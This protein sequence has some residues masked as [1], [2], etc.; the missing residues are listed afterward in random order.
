MTTPHNPDDFCYRHPD[1]RSYVLCQ[2]C[3]RTVCPECQTQAA[4][5]VICPEC[6]KAQRQATP[7]RVRRAQKAVRA[8]DSRPVVTYWMML[9]TA[10]V[11]ITAYIPGSPV[12]GWLMFNSAFIDSGSGAPFEP[13][14]MLTSVFTHLAFWHVGLNILA[15]WMIGRSLAPMLGHGRFLALYLL[16]GFGGSV[17]VALIAPGVSV[18]GASGAVFGLLGALLVVGRHLGANVTGILIILGI[19]LVI[20]F[21]PGFTVAWQAHVGGLATGALIGW[22]FARTRRSDQRPLQIGLLVATG[23]LLLALTV[24]ATFI[25]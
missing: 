7:P 11:F 21:I 16:S 15:I 3:T 1:R 25:Y 2:R 18:V 4:V 23:V 19:N 14:R 13:W 12:G 6:M 20:G 24:L 8:L 10:V 17:G 22:I 9:I 5:G